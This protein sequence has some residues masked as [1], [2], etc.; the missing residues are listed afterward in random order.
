MVVGVWVG[1]RVQSLCLGLVT[2]PRAELYID[3][4]VSGSYGHKHVCQQT[5][6]LNTIVRKMGLQS[7][8]LSC[9]T[10]LHKQLFFS[11]ITNVFSFIALHLKA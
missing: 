8:P 2:S 7:G 6:T 4:V 9:L 3:V 1:R 5:S 11:Y 10:Y